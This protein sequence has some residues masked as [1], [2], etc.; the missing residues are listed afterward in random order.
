M[1]RRTLIGPTEERVSASLCARVCTCVR[2]GKG[3]ASGQRRSGDA[4][5]ANTRDPDDLFSQQ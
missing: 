5:H 3:A 1:P 4:A 2:E